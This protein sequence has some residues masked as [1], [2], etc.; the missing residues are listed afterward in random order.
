MKKPWLRRVGLTAS[1]FS[2]AALSTYEQSLPI[3]IL[4]K[5]NRLNFGCTHGKIIH[6]ALGAEHEY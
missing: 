5:N 4:L 2:V 1:L 3:S 6:I